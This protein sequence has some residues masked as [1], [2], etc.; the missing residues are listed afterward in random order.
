MIIFGPVPSRR[1][2]RS[3]G[4]NNIPPKRCSYSCVYCQLGRTNRMQIKREEFYTPQDICQRVAAKIE[5][6]K[7]QGEALDY[8]TFVCDGEPSLD[9]NLGATI[10]LLQ[11]FGIKIAVITNASLV[12][13]DEVREDLAKADWV[14]L[15][16]D[17]VDK[18]IW[19][20]I[21][22]PHGKLDF[23][24]VLNGTLDFAKSFQ[25]TLVTETMLA[26][27]F[28][29]HRESLPGVGRHIGKLSPAKAYLLVPTRP[30]AEVNVERPSRQKLQEAFWTIS[31][32]ADNTEV[33][34]I[35]G[36]EGERFF[37]AED[38]IKDLLSILSVHPIKEKVMEK[39]VRDKDIDWQLIDDLLKAGKIEEYKY[40]GVKFFKRKIL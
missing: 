36:D 15:K 34:C 24:K 12:W 5:E 28:N 20:R 11:Q 40:E 19:R 6:L 7:A 9:S 37:V 35:T 10:D 13:R 32:L 23:D 3:L 31:E 14:S 25:G 26:A 17:T 33:E 22:R 18:D 8:L 2:G 38:P 30:P 16:I 4:I 27:G 21:N 1:L 29:D 39:L